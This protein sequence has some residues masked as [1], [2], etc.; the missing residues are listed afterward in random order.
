MKKKITSN[1]SS[2]MNLRLTIKNKKSLNDPLSSKKDRKN[3]K[4]IKLK[5]SCIKK[6]KSVDKRKKASNSINLYSKYESFD[7]TKK[8]LL[9]NSLISR[10][11]PEIKKLNKIEHKNQSLTL[12][13]SHKRLY[14]LDEFSNLNEKSIYKH[15]IPLKNKILI[16]KKNG[17]NEKKNK[18]KN[19]LINSLI[20]SELNKSLNKPKGIMR[21]MSKNKILFK[22]MA[23]SKKNSLIEKSRNSNRITLESN[24]NS[25]S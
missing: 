13:N 20:N 22:Y 6:V 16:Y 7:F 24:P 9:N 2:S 10:K 15:K 1:F 17:N 18:L 11:S 23:K 14:S 3:K 5:K 12:K 8:G 4:R 19:N 21:F 25:N